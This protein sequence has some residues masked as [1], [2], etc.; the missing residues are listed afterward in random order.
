[1]AHENGT[2]FYGE[3]IKETFNRNGYKIF[4]FKFKWLEEYLMD[5]VWTYSFVGIAA[6]L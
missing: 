4:D 2:N 3:N 1:M 5:L 6:P